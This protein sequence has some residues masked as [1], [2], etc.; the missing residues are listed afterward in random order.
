MCFVHTL[1]HD[2]SFRSSSPTSVIDHYCNWPRRLANHKPKVFRNFDKWAVSDWHRDSHYQ[3]PSFDHSTKINIGPIQWGEVHEYLARTDS[4]YLLLLPPGVTAVSAN[5]SF[6]QLSDSFFMNT[7][8]C[9]RYP[10]YPECKFNKLF[11]CCSL[12]LVDRCCQKRP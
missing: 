4:Q 10:L 1:K 11:S 12:P 9:F 5:I 3:F 6:P 2:L 8:S 7:L